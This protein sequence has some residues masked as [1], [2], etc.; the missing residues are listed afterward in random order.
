MFIGL[1]KPPLETSAC[2]M[3]Q[4][5]LFFFGKFVFHSVR[6]F[7]KEFYCRIGVEVFITA[8]VKK[9]EIIENHVSK[10]FHFYLCLTSAFSDPLQLARTSMGHDSSAGMFP[11]RH[12]HKS[13]VL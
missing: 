5:I 7:L 12:Y 6:Q 2:G 4:L 1:A 9:P 3:L 10:Y 13:L 8:K 11:M